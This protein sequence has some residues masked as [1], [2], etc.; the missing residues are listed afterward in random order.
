M[1]KR[2]LVFAVALMAVAMLATPAL[3]ET[4]KKIS[5]TIV[6]SGWTVDVGETWMTEGGTYH[7]RGGYLESTSYKVTGDGVNAIYGMSGYSYSDPFFG[8]LNLKTGIGHIQYDSTLVFPGGTFEGVINYR[9]TCI[10]G[11]NGGI[12]L[13]DGHSRGVWHGTGDYQ[14]WTLVRTQARPPPP[15]Q[16]HG[17]L[18][19]P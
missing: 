13:T 17:Y 2:V 19:I 9:G 1:N 16:P 8:N 15:G 6:A 7:T 18:L 5:I 4:P 12:R 14:G 10:I 11:P 3:A